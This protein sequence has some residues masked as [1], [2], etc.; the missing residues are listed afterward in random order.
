MDGKGWRTRKEGKGRRWNEQT[1]EG[2]LLV[3]RRTGDFGALVEFPELGVVLCQHT[4]TGSAR[5]VGGH[6][7]QT[8]S[9]TERGKGHTGQMSRDTTEGERERKEEK[10]LAG[11]QQMRLGSFA[12]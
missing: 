12:V 11:V 1:G 10:V 2:P 8:Q 4:R 6:R 3:Q 7:G 9:P 5:R